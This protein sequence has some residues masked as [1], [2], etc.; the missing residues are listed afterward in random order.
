MNICSVRGN[1]ACSWADKYLQHIVPEFLAAPF[2]YSVYSTPGV[3]NISEPTLHGVSAGIKMNIRW[4]CY[5]N[6]KV[7]T[8]TAQEAMLCVPLEPEL[9]LNVQ[10]KQ[11][12]FGKQK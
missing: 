2:V 11:Q 6:G 9:V 4:V 3:Q 7:G 8:L 12:H 5:M 1:G 10:K